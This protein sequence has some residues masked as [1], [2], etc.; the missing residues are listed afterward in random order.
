MRDPSRGR[1]DRP[2]RDPRRRRRAPGRPRLHPAAGAAPARG[3][4]RVARAGELGTRTGLAGRDEFGQL[5]EAFD[6]MAASLQRHEG[7]LRE[8]VARSRI[9]QERQTMMLHEL[10]PRP[11]HPDD[12]PVPGA[13]GPPGRRPR[14]AA[15]RTHP[16]PVEDPRPAVARRLGGRLL[17][18]GAGERARPFRTTRLTASALRDRPQPAAALCPGARHDGARAHDQRGQVRRALERR[19]PN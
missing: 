4:R 16:F 15:G 6:A 9:L 8:E 3:G 1:A 17:A 12:R 11:Q 10:N 7:E 2:R 19:R 14:R 13:A 5:G 18:H